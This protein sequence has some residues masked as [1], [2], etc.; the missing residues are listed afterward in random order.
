MDAVADASPAARSWD[1]A[2]AEPPGSTATMKRVARQLLIFAVLLLLFTAVRFPYERLLEDEL[3][4]LRRQAALNG[5]FFELD[6]TS[7]RFPGRLSFARFAAL[8]ARNHAPVPVVLTDGTAELDFLPFLL[9]KAQIAG[10]ARAY[11]GEVK[12]QLARSLGGADAGFSLSAEGLDLA[13]HP[14]LAALGVS[15]SAQLEAEGSIDGGRALQSL[16]ADLHLSGA[17]LRYP[18]KLGGAFAI[19]ELGGIDAEIVLTGAKE[20]FKI[21][22]C[23]AV[24]SHGTIS[25]SGAAVLGAGAVRSARLTLELALNDAGREVF[26]PYLALAGGTAAAQARGAWTITLEVKNGAVSSFKATPG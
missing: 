5:V 13:A 6:G 26:G 15:G 10:E 18:G 12:M 17:A 4:L 16:N 25:C 11:G 21:E 22:R 19:P 8:V 7:V 9:L 20:N 23:R 2:R 3:D 14:S 1:A 24:T